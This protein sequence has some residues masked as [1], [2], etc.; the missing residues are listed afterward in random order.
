MNLILNAA[1]LSLPTLFFGYAILANLSLL[2]DPLPEVVLE[3][4]GLLSGGLTRD[5]DG[6]Y[7][8][9]LPHIEP[10]FGLVGATR[11][12]VLN[13]ARQGVLV[14]SQGWLFSTE[15]AR[16]APSDADLSAIADL[17]QDIAIQLLHNGTHLV[18]VPLPAKIDIAR[19]HSPEPAFGA[20]LAGLHQRFS[21]KVAARGVTVVNAREQLVS[22]GAQAFF[23]TD[24]HWT[25]KGADI[26]ATAVAQSGTVVHGSLTYDRKDGLPKTLT[27]DLV[28]F[29]TTAAMAPS[30][31]LAAEEVL[32]VVQTPRGPDLD[33][34]GDA[35]ADIV[36]VGTSY[37]ANPDWGFADSLMRALGRDVV[38]VAEQGQ[39]PLEPM[40]DYLASADFR[41]A[42]PSVVI[43]EIPVRYL[44][45]PALW[46]D[47]GAPAYNTASSAGGENADG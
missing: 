34:F 44:T 26:V 45:D 24:T 31:G 28:A 15:E 16:P 8:K 32:P 30:I 1:R 21:A 3:E 11:F 14:G 38:S 47:V 27:G 12:V 2:T 42:P 5:L 9:L 43:W 4:G 19:V 35:A 18:V 22:A 7:K 10:S 40:R 39:G 17:I 20:T 25:P 41:T 37:S 6:V 29:V 46:Q 23:A 36:L 13:E 33:V